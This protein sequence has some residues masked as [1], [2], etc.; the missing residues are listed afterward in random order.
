MRLGNIVQEI[1]IAF[2]RNDIAYQCMTMWFSKAIKNTK[3][4]C[5]VVKPSFILHSRKLSLLYKKLTA[6]VYRKVSLKYVVQYNRK[7]SLL[8]LYI[9]KSNII[10]AWLFFNMW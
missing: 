1:I 10:T 2:D 5:I 3:E 9:I 4:R 6:T 8:E 7:S